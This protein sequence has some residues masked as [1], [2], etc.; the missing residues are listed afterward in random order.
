M[1]HNIRAT[2]REEYKADLTYKW[3][4]GKHGLMAVLGMFHKIWPSSQALPPGVSVIDVIVEDKFGSVPAAPPSPDNNASQTTDPS[5]TGW[6]K[7]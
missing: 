6:T 1:S 7:V 2:S 3:N 4:S 5:H